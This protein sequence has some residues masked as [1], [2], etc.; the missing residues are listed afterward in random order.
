[1]S[2]KLSRNELLHEFRIIVRHFAKVMGLCSLQLSCARARATSRF[3]HACAIPHEKRAFL[4][5]AR[6]EGRTLPS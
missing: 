5:A 1:M 6:E 4:G 3:C 2:S